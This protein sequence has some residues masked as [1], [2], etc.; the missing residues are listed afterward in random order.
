MDGPLEIGVSDKKTITTIPQLFGAWAAVPGKIVA[1]G[2]GDLVKGSAAKRSDL[3]N[4]KIRLLHQYLAATFNC[5]AFGCPTDP[6]VT[7]LMDADAAWDAMDIGLMNAAAAVL[8]DYNEDGNV[9]LSIC[10]GC[11]TFG[12]LGPADPGSARDAADACSD[13]MTMM[14]PL[15]FTPVPAPSSC[16]SETTGRSHWDDLGYSYHEYDNIVHGKRVKKGQSANAQSA[17]EPTTT[18]PPPEPINQAPIAEAGA[19][20][21][22]TDADQNGVETVTLD[23]SGSTDPDGTITNWEWKEGGTVLGTGETF[24]LELAQG[25]HTITLT[26]TDNEGATSTD[27]VGINVKKPSGKNK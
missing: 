22:I 20:Q 4:A 11:M 24:T 9:E 21:Q 3:D 5:H 17:P 19:T 25:S 7:A 2:D 18:E 1:D 6:V 14:L 10:M 27:T 13:D 26:V 16:V 12:P 23:G 8:A 15:S